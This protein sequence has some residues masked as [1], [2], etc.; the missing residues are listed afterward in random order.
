[1]KIHEIGEFGFI[2]RFKSWFEALTP[3]GVIGIGDDCA[4]IPANEKEDWVIT[5]DLL[6]EGV[7]FLKDA[8]SPFQLGYKS[9]AVNLSDI[10][11]MGATPVGSFL[12]MAISLETEVEYLDDFMQGYR[13]LS[14]K[15]NTPLLGG[16][17]TKSMRHLAINVCVVGKCDKGQVKRRNTAMADDRVCVTGFLGDSAGGLQVLLNKLPKTEEHAYLL[18]RHHLP[19]PR[20][21]EG[22]F[23]SSFSAVHAMMDISDGIASDLTHI[24]KASGKNAHIY[25]DRLPVSDRL[26]KVTGKQG[27]NMVEL[28]VAGGEDYE[29]L[30]TI[31][32]EKV[33]VIADS[34]LS[35][36]GRPLTVIGE[37]GEGTP[38]IRWFQHEAEVRLR[39]GGFDHFQ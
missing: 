32:P 17:T 18:T 14:Q 30:C 11:A 19:E 31:A 28:A 1:M 26:K 12:S 7:H 38:H 16:D 39:K 34:F 27:W 10:A 35:R 25:V 24:L 9:L 8:I 15:Y 4:V 29:L 3:A 5:T 20:L 6:M 23:L 21:D 33:Q 22:R 36:F 2:E 13:E 37:I